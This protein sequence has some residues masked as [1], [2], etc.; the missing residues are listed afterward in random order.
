MKSLGKFKFKEIQK[1][2]GGTFTNSKGDEI[3]YNDSYK[4][5]VDEMTNNGIYERVF[6]I[7]I[8]SPLVREFAELKPYTDITIEFDI[9]IYGSKVSVIPVAIN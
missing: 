4:I 8:D 2:D 7:P 9:N 3:T 6:K 5:K 1:V